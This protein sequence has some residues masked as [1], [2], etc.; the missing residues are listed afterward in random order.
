MAATW[1]TVVDV[2]VHEGVNAVTAVAMTT[3][4]VTIVMVIG[5][6]DVGDSISGTKAG[7]D[8]DT[9]VVVVTVMRTVRAVMLALVPTEVIQ[10]DSVDKV[11]DEEGVTHDGDGDDNARKD[12]HVGA[13][14]VGDNQD[15]AVTHQWRR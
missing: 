1:D 7:D 8:E 14:G 15:V 2:G 9:G 6:G 13:D 4:G 3:V 10:F 12:G 11:A 5:W